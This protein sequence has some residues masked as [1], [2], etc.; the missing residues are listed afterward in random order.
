[1]ELNQYLMRFYMYCL[2]CVT[3]LLRQM[4]GLGRRKGLC[5][6]YCNRHSIALEVRL[7]GKE[8]I[9]QEM[10]LHRRGNRRLELGGL[11]ELKSWCHDRRLVSNMCEILN[12][13]EEGGCVSFRRLESLSHWTLTCGCLGNLKVQ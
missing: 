12:K 10:S 4:Y 7:D 13:R 2:S 5:Y 1:M 9:S 11:G 8:A 3:R 6:T